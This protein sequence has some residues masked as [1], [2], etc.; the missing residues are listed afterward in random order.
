MGLPWSPNPI[1]PTL[2]SPPQLPTDR[3]AGKQL[4]RMALSPNLSL[5]P[6]IGLRSFF[7]A[8]PFG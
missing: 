4:S 7:S 1:K 6:V 5:L 2:T 8:F 3:E